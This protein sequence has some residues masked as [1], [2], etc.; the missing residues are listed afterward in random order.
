V[1]TTV[2]PS[3]VDCLKIWEPQTPTTLRACP[4]PYT[5]CFIRGVYL[6]NLV[7]TG[8]SMYTCNVTTKPSLNKYLILSRYSGCLDYVYNPKEARVRKALRQQTRSHARRTH[9]VTPSSTSQPATHQQ[10]GSTSHHQDFQHVLAGAQG[11]G[12]QSL[13][14]TRVSHRTHYNTRFIRV[15]DIC[16]FVCTGAQLGGGGPRTAESK[17]LQ[18]EC[19]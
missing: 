19:F 18:T 6:E 10:W 16:H 9:T 8:I 15:G 13:L 1:L 4:S 5:D 7:V 11:H 12:G 17:E 2:S 3:C 14:S